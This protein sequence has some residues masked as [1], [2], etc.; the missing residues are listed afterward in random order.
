MAVRIA[1]NIIPAEQCGDSTALDR[2]LLD[3]DERQRR[4]AVLIGE[5]GT[6]FLLD[7]PHPATLRD[8]D[9]LILDDGSIVRVVAVVEPLIEIT[10]ESR[11][12]L[13]RFAWHLGNR[14]AAVQVLGNGLRIRK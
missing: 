2:V 11:R 10:A 13:A 1:M 3:S 6:K 7:L 8:G 5:N 14:H 9:G 12:D 4:R